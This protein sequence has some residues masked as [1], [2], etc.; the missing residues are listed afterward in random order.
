[1]FRLGL[2][3][4]GGFA[5]VEAVGGLLLLLV[6]NAGLRKLIDRL[7]A[8]DIAMDRGDWL[9]HTFQHLAA[10]LSIQEQHF[11]ALHLIAHGTVKLAVVV[12]LARRLPIAFPLGIV[13]LAGFVTYQMHR[14]LTEGATGQMAMSLSDSALIALIAWEW[15]QH[16]SAPAITA[17][18]R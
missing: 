9:A 5:M 1:M 18:V 17:P 8:P 13:V 7:T 3:L 12:L 6:P 2:A 14:Y 4:K 15:R 11:Y 16:R 10:S